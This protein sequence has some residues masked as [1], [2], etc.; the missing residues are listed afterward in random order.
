MTEKIEDKKIKMPSDSIDSFDF[1]KLRLSQ[2][3][4]EMAGVKKAILTIPVR[5]PN[6][7]E[8]FRVRPGEDWRFETAVLE[9]KLERESYLV[10]KTLWPILVNEI[11]PKV[12]F[13]VIS[14]QNILSLWPIRLPG[15]DGRIDQWN[16]SALEAAKLAQEKWIRLSANMSL[17]AYEVSVAEADFPEPEWPDISFKEILKIAFKDNFIQTTDHPVIQKL[18]GLI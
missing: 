13:T 2:N 5:K 16:R 18:R 4:S 11:A 9:L 3:F 14:R 12:L 1:D 6:R 8:F 17:G 10:D 15:E 7:H